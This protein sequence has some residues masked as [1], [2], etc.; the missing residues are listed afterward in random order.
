MPH[1]RYIADVAGEIDPET[2]FLAYSEI[3]LIGPRQLTGKTE[4]ILPV[5]THRCLGFGQGGPQRV[6]YTAQTADAGKEKWR[7]VHLPRLKASPTISRRFRE[8]K[9]AN[10]EAFL[11]DNG[12]IWSP[13]S[14]TGKSSGTGDTLDMGVI[15]EAW[16]RPDARTELGMRPAMLTRPWKQLWLMS[17]IPGLSRA[18]PGDWPYLAHKRQVGRARV[19]AD[20]R[21]GMAYFEFAAADGLDPGNPNTWWSCM[22]GLGIFPGAEQAV[23]DDFDAL[24]LVDF[25]AEYL[26]WPPSTSPQ[27]RWT[28]IP[29][30]LWAAL[31]DPGSEIVGAPA[32]AVEISE[33]QTRAFIGAAGRRFDGH[34]HVEGVEPG[35][36]I[37]PV[38]AGVQWVEPR[39]LEMIEAWKP[40]TVVIDPRRPANALI[41]PL[42]RRGIDVTTP[43]QNEIAGA[44]GRFVIATGVTEPGETP[45]VERVYHLGQPELDDALAHARKLDMPGGAF[46]IVQKGHSVGLGALY[47]CILAMHGHDL[48][49]FETVPEPDI[50]V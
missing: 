46:T 48:K 39:L 18:Q 41:T 12:S 3:V 33:D 28:L 9:T 8:R 5:M 4:L 2:G 40:V 14:T 24:D 47:V 38:T 23:A 37:G 1:Q 26:G 32:L 22:P 15:D 6:M 42:R 19:D 10:Q 16:S 7:D 20:V 34:R 29:K 13:G 36:V 17:M 21:R 25:C 30:L 44:C 27:A 43:N 50:F 31:C 49:G 11:W 35:G 45:S